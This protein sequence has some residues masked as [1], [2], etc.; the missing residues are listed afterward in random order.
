MT[1]AH[2]TS[3]SMLC[4]NTFLCP[5]TLFSSLISSW[6]GSPLPREET[7]LSLFQPPGVYKEPGWGQNHQSHLYCCLN[8]TSTAASGCSM[9]RLAELVPVS[10]CSCPPRGLQL[11][12]SQ[13]NS[14]SRSCLQV[15]FW[16]WI[17]CHLTSQERACKCTGDFHSQVT[18]P[19][20][21]VLT[22]ALLTFTP[23]QV[24]SQ[25]VVASAPLTFT[26]KSLRC[27]HRPIRDRLATVEWFS[28]RGAVVLLLWAW[29]CHKVP[30]VLC[31][32]RP[33]WAWFCLWGSICSDTATCRQGLGRTLRF[34]IF[35]GS[36][37]CSTE[38]VLANRHHLLK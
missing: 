30:R 7:K 37:S 8:N 33:L 4:D 17:R 24:T 16:L 14:L 11:F 12:H 34:P 21:I 28:F 35:C 23:C 13:V 19:L 18:L 5:R 25:D 38:L 29:H 15:H 32:E 31:V 22:S 10:P 26:H 3:N 2:L 20:K 9:P 6:L 36:S 27:Y 1:F